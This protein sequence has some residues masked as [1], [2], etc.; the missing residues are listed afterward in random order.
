MYYILH[1][2][3]TLELNVIVM[4]RHP[5]TRHPVTG[6]K[7]SY[8]GVLKLS[9]RYGGWGGSIVLVTNVCLSVCVYSLYNNCIYIYLNVCACVCVY[10]Y[11]SS[12]LYPG[13]I[14]ICIKIQ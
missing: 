6:V 14:I 5:V 13:M 11:K 10:C 4:T 1:T 2:P 3:L 12:I 9:F 8:P 7:V